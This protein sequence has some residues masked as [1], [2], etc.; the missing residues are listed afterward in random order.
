LWTKVDLVCII[1]FLILLSLSLSLGTS[2]ES[3]GSRRHGFSSAL[4]PIGTHGEFHQIC[5]FQALTALLPNN[6]NGYNSR[7][8][9]MR[10][11]RISH[12]ITLA[13]L[14]YFCF[15][16]CICYDYGRKEK[17]KTYPK[18][19]GVSQEEARNTSIVPLSLH[20]LFL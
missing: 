3:N 6:L 15:F 1:Q 16:F 8:P 9:R 7:Q 2:K 4:F 17:D 13:L 10:I 20:L 12:R 14:P 5:K 11:T 18:I 19:V